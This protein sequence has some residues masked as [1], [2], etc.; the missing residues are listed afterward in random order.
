MTKRWVHAM[1]DETNVG[2]TPGISYQMT[3]NL[4]EP[5][6]AFVVEIGVKRLSVNQKRRPAGGGIKR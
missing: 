6:A 2:E 4:M 3:R 5:K 1:D